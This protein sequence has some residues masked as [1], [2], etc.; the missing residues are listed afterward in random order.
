MNIPS[1]RIVSVI[2]AFFASIVLIA[3]V[4]AP[5]I[6]ATTTTS[7]STVPSASPVGTLAGSH[8]QPNGFTHFNIVR[9]THVAP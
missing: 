5:A 4:A 1:D 3:A 8:W 6:S 2:T 9:A 7:F